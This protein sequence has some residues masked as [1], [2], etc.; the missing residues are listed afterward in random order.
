MPINFRGSHEPF[1]NGTFFRL[2]G[3][4]GDLV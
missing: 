3:A 1:G 2:E 4:R